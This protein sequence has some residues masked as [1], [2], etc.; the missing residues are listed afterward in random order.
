MKNVGVIIIRIE[1][2][3]NGKFHLRIIAAYAL[4]E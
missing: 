2:E 3:K 4:I 1:K